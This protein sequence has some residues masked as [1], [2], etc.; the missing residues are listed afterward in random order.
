M[1]NLLVFRES[2]VRCDISKGG[3]TAGLRNFLFSFL[4]SLLFA[5]F[6]HAQISPGP[7]TKAHQSLSGTTQCASCH[8]FGT[9]TPTSNSLDFHTDIPQLLPTHHHY[10][11]PL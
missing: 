7:L 10:P 2:A 9:S 3:Q 6:A 5:G 11:P 8:Q 1:E 4:L